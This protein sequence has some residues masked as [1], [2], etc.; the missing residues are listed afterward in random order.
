MST[1]IL[2]GMEKNTVHP[3][4]SSL[5]KKKAKEEAVFGRMARPTTLPCL[6]VLR[7]E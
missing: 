7:P 6:G 4:V 2:T 3:K 5:W 1:A